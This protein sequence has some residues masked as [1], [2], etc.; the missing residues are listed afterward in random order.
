MF[1]DDLAR[2]GVHDFGKG[3]ERIALNRLAEAVDAKGVPTRSERWRRARELDRLVAA[4]KPFIEPRRNRPPNV[5]RNL[6]MPTLGCER[7]QCE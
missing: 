7:G 6:L 5:C 1:A 4:G 3:Q 2:I